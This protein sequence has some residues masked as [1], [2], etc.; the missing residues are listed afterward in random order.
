[1]FRQSIVTL[2]ENKNIPE[3]PLMPLVKEMNH[4]VHLVYDLNRK[5]LDE[6]MEQL[7]VV[8]DVAKKFYPLQGELQKI[9]EE[10]FA[11]VK[12][13]KI[14][15]LILCDQDAKKHKLLMQLDE[16]VMKECGSSK[17]GKLAD[18]RDTDVLIKQYE[19]AEDKINAILDKFTKENTYENS[20][21]I[22]EK[23]RA[24]NKKKFTDIGEQ[25]IDKTCD[26]RDFVASTRKGLL[27]LLMS[28]K[29]LSI[30]I[31]KVVVKKID[32]LTVDPQACFAA[33][34]EYEKVKKAESAQPVSEDK[35]Q[36]EMMEKYKAFKNAKSVEMEPIAVEGIHL[37][38]RHMAE[39]TT[40]GSDDSD[41]DSPSKKNSSSGSDSDSS[42]SK[43]PSVVR[44]GLFVAQQSVSKIASVMTPAAKGLTSASR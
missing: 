18:I 7:E 17:G 42:A 30:V 29:K 16:L 8:V 24:I 19:D 4:H 9:Q 10:M 12:S 6:Y 34:Q 38:E 1:M 44:D 36:Q 40:S 33:L 35:K 2:S 21:E 20:T 39:A 43:K 27:D 14:N 26:T 5:M 13:G 22:A 3:N 32:E 11:H 15:Y 37:Q 28:L 41:A 25:L 31:G 23:L